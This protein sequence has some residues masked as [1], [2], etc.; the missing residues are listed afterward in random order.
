V[1]LLS[2]HDEITH[3]KL[4]DERHDLL[5]RAGLRWESMAT[6]AATPKNHPE[7]GQKGA[8]LVAGEVFRNRRPRRAAIVAVI[9]VRPKSW[10]SWICAWPHLEPGPKLGFEALLPF[11]FPAPFFLRIHEGPRSFPGEMPSRIARPSLRRADFDFLHFET[12]VTF[13][14]TLPSCRRVRRRPP[15]GMETARERLSPR[16]SSLTAKPGRR[17]ASALSSWIATSNLCLALSSQNSWLVAPP[18]VLHFADKG[19]TGKA[20]RFLRQTDWPAF[21]FGAVGFRLLGRILPGGKC[22]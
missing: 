9:G 20:H 22:R 3:A 1:G 17:R 11:S 2:L 12:P 16:M 19:F 6:T 15:P 8:K 21:R 4:F 13:C 5:L 7:H 14:N 18:T 10:V